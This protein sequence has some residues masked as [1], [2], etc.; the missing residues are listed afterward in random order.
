MERDSDD[1]REAT[2]TTRIAI[3]QSARSTRFMLAAWGTDLDY[4]GFHLYRPPRRLTR[5]TKEVLKGPWSA[6]NITT[7]RGSARVKVQDRTV[8]YDDRADFAVTPPEFPEEEG[9]ALR[10]AITGIIIGA[11]MWSAAIFGFVQIFKR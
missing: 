10:G 3:N 2:T 6:R 4:T 8:I 1:K 5:L 11:G 9:S 7:M